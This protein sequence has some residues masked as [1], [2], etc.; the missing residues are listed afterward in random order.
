MNFIIF[1][2]L[3]F[4][5]VGKE[6][7][8]SNLVAG[9]YMNGEGTGVQQTVNVYSPREKPAKVWTF[10]YTNT[11]MS[12][13]LLNC[14]YGNGFTFETMVIKFDYPNAVTALIGYQYYGVIKSCLARYLLLPVK[15]LGTR[16]LVTRVWET[17]FFSIVAAEEKTKVKLRLGQSDAGF[18]I[19]KR[20]MAPFFSKSDEETITLEKYEGFQ[21]WFMHVKRKRSIGFVEIE[22]NQKV[23]VVNGAS[24]LKNSSIKWVL[25]R[26]LYSADIVTPTAAQSRAYVVPTFLIPKGRKVIQTSHVLVSAL[27]SDT[28][29]EI[30]GSTNYYRGY[31]PFKGGSHNWTSTHHDFL[32]IV[33][34]NKPIM[35]NIVRQ[36]Y[37]IIR[38]SQHMAL[39]FSYA[40]PPQ[41]FYNYHVFRRH[42]DNDF[43][44]AYVLILRDETHATVIEWNNVVLADRTCDYFR[45][46]HSPY[47]ALRCAPYLLK[48]HYGLFESFYHSHIR[49]AVYFYSVDVYNSKVSIGARTVELENTP[50]VNSEPFIDDLV[51]ND[52]DGSIDEE[53][54]NGLDDD[55]DG[56]IDED[57]TSVLHDPGDTNCTVWASWACTVD[58][59]AVG[60]WHRTRNCTSTRS[61]LLKPFDMERQVTKTCNM[62]KV[63][64]HEVAEKDKKK[65]KGPCPRGRWSKDCGKLCPAHCKDNKC[66][67]L[68]GACMSCVPGYRGFKCNKA[69]PAGRYGFQCQR[70]CPDECTRECNHV[71]GFCEVYDLS[72]WWIVSTIVVLLVGLGPLLFM[73]M[74]TT[75]NVRKRQF[76][77]YE[78]EITA[79]E[80]EKGG[81]RNGK[82]RRRSE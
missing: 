37:I 41:S 5:F 59:E 23:A 76:D 9:I 28:T 3:F 45:L 57:T 61:L 65:Q 46:S 78:M 42:K 82:L 48:S 34:A 44:Q 43:I 40:V 24:K 33:Y 25:C 74:Q 12:E 17:G 80:E 69:C 54:H 29:F 10:N 66:R 39:Q 51:D 8:S 53:I 38:R 55:G 30:K 71:T 36:R 72:Y 20:Q 56:V 62:T 16:Y 7:A 31:I 6:L 14:D 21:M 26:S 68:S 79:R 1:I 67:V 81:N 32:Y 58:C 22:A 13:Q 70:K 50:C 2:L 75:D 47:V 15:A 11:E 19:P 49:F 27:E 18:P 4:S 77:E 64:C 63:L 52:C 35:V 73:F 60:V